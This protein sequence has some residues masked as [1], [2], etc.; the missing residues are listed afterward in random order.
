[1]KDFIF[2]YQITKLSVHVENIRIPEQIK[3]L[4]NAFLTLKPWHFNIIWR[5]NSQPTIVHP[6][7]NF[8]WFISLL[9]L[10]YQFNYEVLKKDKI[11]KETSINTL[12]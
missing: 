12:N 2:Y 9:W 1:M 7:V 6:I 3:Y 8:A 10:L 5:Q 11:S 4:Q